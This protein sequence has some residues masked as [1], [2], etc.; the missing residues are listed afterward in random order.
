[1]ENYR[2]FYKELN[3]IKTV[4][5]KEK[6]SKEIAIEMLETIQE[7]ER[8]FIFSQERIDYY[9]KLIPRLYNIILTQFDKKELFDY[10]L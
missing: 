2:N 4:L 10:I 6:I 3:E 7:I 1:M 5:G 8:Y 9:K